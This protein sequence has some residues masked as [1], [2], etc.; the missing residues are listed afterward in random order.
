MNYTVNPSFA[1]YVLLVIDPELFSFVDYSRN[2]Q[3][4]PAHS[5]SVENLSGNNG[6]PH[7][8]LCFNN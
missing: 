4:V 6:A 7:S 8:P 5:L 1:G 3:D 2:L